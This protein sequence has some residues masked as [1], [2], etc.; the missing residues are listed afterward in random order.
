MSTQSPDT[1]AEVDTIDVLWCSHTLPFQADSNI[2]GPEFPY[3]SFEFTAD[4]GE[5]HG[6][7]GITLRPTIL[8]DSAVADALVIAQSFDEDVI[9][10]LAALPRSFRDLPTDN[11][12][13]L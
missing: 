1:T 4:T 8:S 12:D 13:D 6:A 7:C 3:K 2:F 5:A 9:A 10:G 11:D